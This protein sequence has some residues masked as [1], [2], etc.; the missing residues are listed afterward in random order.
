MEF[1]KIVFQILSKEAYTFNL[2]RYDNRENYGAAVPIT[3]AK[4]LPQL[5]PF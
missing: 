5:R 4:R 2:K 3:L 1:A